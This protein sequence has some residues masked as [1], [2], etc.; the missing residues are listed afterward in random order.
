M[1]RRS[2]R[3]VIARARRES[4]VALK[5]H[6]KGMMWVD[7]VTVDTHLKIFS[8]DYMKYF[9]MEKKAHAN[10]KEK[11]MTYRAISSTGKEY[12]KD[13]PSIKIALDCNKQKLSILARLEIAPAW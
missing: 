1:S 8:D 6:I 3:K 10:I 2:I 7:E 4:Y 11:G 9:E 12:D 5:Y 13:N